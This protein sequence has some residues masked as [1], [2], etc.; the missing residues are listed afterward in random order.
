M[1]WAP[2]ATKRLMRGGRVLQLQQQQL[3]ATVDYR[4]PSLNPWGV[5]AVTSVKVCMR[6]VL[7]V[8]VCAG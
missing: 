4:D 5:T 3:P 7:M 2:P 6:A 8:T 1:K